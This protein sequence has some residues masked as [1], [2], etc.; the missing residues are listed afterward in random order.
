MHPIG[1]GIKVLNHAHTRDRSG[2]NQPAYRMAPRPPCSISRERCELH[3]LQDKQDS[4][5]ATPKQTWISRLRSKTRKPAEMPPKPS[6]HLVVICS[7][8]RYP[9][10]T[11][12]K[13]FT[14]W[15]AAPCFLCLV[16]RVPWLD[17]DHARVQE[18]MLRVRSFILEMGQRGTASMDIRMTFMFDRALGGGEAYLQQAIGRD[19]VFTPDVKDIQVTVRVDDMAQGISSIYKFEGRR[20]NGLD[21]DGV[22][23]LDEDG[24]LK[25]PGQIETR[26]PCKIDRRVCEDHRGPN[27]EQALLPAPV[28]YRFQ[29][30]VNRA[31]A[32]ARE[33]VSSI[34]GRPNQNVDLA[35]TCADF[36]HPVFKSAERFL[37][38]PAPCCLWLEVQVH[39]RDG[40]ERVKVGEYLDKVSKFIGLLAIKGTVAMDITYKIFLESYELHRCEEYLR[41]AL[42]HEGLRSTGVKHVDF[43]IHVEQARSHTIKTYRF[44][45]SREDRSAEFRGQNTRNVL[46]MGMI[47]GTNDGFT[48][49]L[50]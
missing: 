47:V 31:K 18:Y 8:F 39:C 21:D 23:V 1:Y 46:E 28:P 20:E 26:P 42:G 32:K 35:I 36:R 2:N 22:R 9:V 48:Q 3:L 30:W 37:R 14:R 6:K 49:S 40:D 13:L 43:R 44:K 11:R 50:D 38:S 12:L 16:V 29:S 5:A 33:V 25:P 45:G 7:D 17:N 15:S 34:K 10:T 24:E 41:A 4:S 19:G 27:N